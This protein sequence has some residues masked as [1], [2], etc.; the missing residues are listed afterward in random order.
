MSRFAYKSNLEA[1]ILNGVSLT[2][3]RWEGVPCIVGKNGSGKTTIASLLAALYKPHSGSIHLI[4]RHQL[5]RI[6]SRTCGR[7]SVQVVP[8]SP[9][10]FKVQTVLENVRYSNPSASKSDAQKAMDLAN[11]RICGQARRWTGALA[12]RPQWMPVFRRSTSK[13]PFCWV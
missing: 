2:L 8:Q 7:T 6:G 13:G 12:R 4:R 9:A 1:K 10:L 11:C 5:S 3:K